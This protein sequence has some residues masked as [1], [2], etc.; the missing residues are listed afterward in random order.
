M[1]T[2]IRDVE[3]L[4]LGLLGIKYLKPCV[5]WHYFLISWKVH[6]CKCERL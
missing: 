1:Q 5:L 6:V 3:T 4:G 2:F